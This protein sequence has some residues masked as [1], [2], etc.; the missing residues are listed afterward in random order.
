MVQ[1]IVLDQHARGRAP[2]SRQV[3]AWS[4]IAPRMNTNG[5]ANATWVGISS[6]MIGR[7]EIL[8]ARPAQLLD[9]RDPVMVRI[10]E[11][12][13]ARRSRTRRCRRDRARARANQRRSFG[14]ASEPD[15]DRRAPKNIA[16]YFDSSAAPTA[17]P[18]ASHHAPRPVSSTLASEEQHEAGGHQQRR[19]RRHDHACRP[20]PSCV[21]LSRIALVAATR[22]RR[23][24]S[25]PSDRPHSSSAARAGSRPAARRARY[26]RRSSCRRG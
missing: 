19:I 8:D 22:G 5:V 25:R 16:V 17:T 23:T 14:T 4:P 20:T 18:T 7:A 26:R 1:N 11:H 21:T 9:E 13:P 3:S 24:G 10:P 6:A 15:Q 2:A 12:A